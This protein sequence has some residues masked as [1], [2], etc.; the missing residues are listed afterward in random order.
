MRLTGEFGSFTGKVA[1]WQADS[2]SGFT[3]FPD[4]SSPK[5]AGAL[6]WSQVQRVDERVGHAGRDAV[7]GALLG[8]ALG[9]AIPWIVYANGDPHAE[10]VPGV[11][12]VVVG[13]FVGAFVGGVI[14]SG[15]FHWEYVYQRP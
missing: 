11:G 7:W 8:G 2:L 14:G 1:R 3:S 12:G 10:I 13:A 4:S 9:L 5:P 6:H 15:S